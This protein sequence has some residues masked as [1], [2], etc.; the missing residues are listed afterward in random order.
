LQ[1]GL[2]A[3]HVLLSPAV[4][5]LWNLL[6]RAMSDRTASMKLAA[7]VLVTVTV[8]LAVGS[9]QALAVG[10]H[11]FCSAAVAVFAVAS[12]LGL[13]TRLRA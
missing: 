11:Y 12:T 13:V 8:A 3:L 5:V 6:R 10:T 1:C 2:L 7:G 4:F 9:G